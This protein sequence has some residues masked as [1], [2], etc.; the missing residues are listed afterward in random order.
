MLKY[1]ILI[2]CGLSFLF[3]SCANSDKQELSQTESIDSAQW[4][5]DRSI[6]AHG[7]YQLT[8]QTIRFDFRDRTYTA[9]YSDDGSFVFGRYWTKKDSSIVDVLNNEGLV[10][11]INDEAQNISEE[12]QGR[13]AASVNSV[14]Y[15][16]FLPYRLNDAA[17]IK[18]YLGIR[19]YENRNY[20]IVGVSFKQEGGGEDYSDEYVYWFNA[21]NFKLDYF[22][23]NYREEE[24]GVRFRK[25]FEAHE[26]GGMIFNQY[27]NYACENIDVKLSSLLDSLKQGRLE[28]I[29]QIETKN[30]RLE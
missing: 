28:M 13:Y 27:I 25:A 9:K 1:L 12:W 3:N 20:H 19:R 17:V 22:A 5:V 26:V 15:F 30:I 6:K 14:I 21:E 4:V 23:Y 29:S 11:Y 2:S 16:A 18:E 24:Q 10:R 8:K 7:F